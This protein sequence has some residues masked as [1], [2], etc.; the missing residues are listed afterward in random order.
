M[1]ENQ[2]VRAYGAAMEGAAALG[3]AAPESLLPYSKREIKEAIIAEAK[4]EPDKR[5]R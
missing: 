3:F 5:R 1:K 2:I 4:R